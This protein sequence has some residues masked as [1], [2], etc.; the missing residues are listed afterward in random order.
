[1]NFS[2]R[3]EMPTA[4]VH[5][6]GCDTTFRRSKTGA[7]RT[8]DTSMKVAITAQTT[9]R[10]HLDEGSRLHSPL[11]STSG[12]F[13]NDNNAHAQDSRAMAGRGDAPEERRRLQSLSRI[14]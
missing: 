5:S 2:T 12:N 7:C 10:T 9:N 4:R 8:P 13:L 1:M 3:L 14:C 11:A 6:A